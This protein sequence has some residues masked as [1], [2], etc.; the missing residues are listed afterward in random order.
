MTRRRTVT[1]AVVAVA[2]VVAA[3]VLLPAR[4][5]VGQRF[6]LQRAEA[7]LIEIRK[8]NDALADKIARLSEDDAIERQ[9][10]EHF[11][12][13]YPGEESYTVPPPDTATVNL[14]RVWPF[15]LLQEP[16]A[17]AVARGALDPP[18]RR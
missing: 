7:E 3:L 4:N 6:A 12:L 14:P 10:R 17:R 16:L 5:W 13:V 18:E 15:D 9:A 2:A 8:A 1:V 11:G